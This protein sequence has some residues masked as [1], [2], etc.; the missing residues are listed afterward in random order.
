MLKAFD[1]CVL[2]GRLHVANLSSTLDN[3]LT[4]DFLRL[5]DADGRRLAAHHTRR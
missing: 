2:P 3:L 5:I 4:V 1:R